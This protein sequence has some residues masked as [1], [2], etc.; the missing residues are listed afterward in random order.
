MGLKYRREW[1]WG[2]GVLI[3]LILAIDWYTEL[4]ALGA[5]ARFLGNLLGATWRL[6]LETAVALWRIILEAAFAL[7]RFIAFG[8]ERFSLVIA[9]V[10]TSKVARFFTSI[11]ASVTLEY[12]FAGSWTGRVR[13]LKERAKSAGMA[14]RLWWLR[15]HLVVKLAVVTIMI[16][17]Q[18]SLHWVILLFPI[19]FMVPYLVKTVRFVQK[20][21]LDNAFTKWYLTRFG[22]FH[23]FV[24]R[25]L[26]TH[27]TTRSVTACIRT[28]R[29]YFN[30]GWRIWKYDPR[31]RAR[32]ASLIYQD[33][34]LRMV[35]AKT[36]W[37]AGEWRTR[38]D[39]YR[40]RPLLSGEGRK[41]KKEAAE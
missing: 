39:Q 21:V 25:T 4:D 2:F 26:R 9:A 30:A 15:Q 20:T 1:W 13:Q 17:V 10:A 6:L 24:V 12:M 18:I 19:G 31:F 8:A 32:E 36:S 29:L 37:W 5:T 11:A 28:T 27:A 38:F 23:G 3:A 7:W 22:S 33:L 35:F 14:A 41:Q 40:S 34:W 16:V